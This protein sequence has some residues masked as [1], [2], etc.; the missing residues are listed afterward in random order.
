MIH[1]T[2][3]GTQSTLSARDNRTVQ[4]LFG[5]A[6]GQRQSQTFSQ[7]GRDG[8][9]QGAAGAVGMAGIHPRSA[10][11]FPPRGAPQQDGGVGAPA[12]A[13]LVQ[14]PLGAPGSTT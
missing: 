7:A 4:I 11:G 3:A 9:R 13:P 12:R 10:E 14:T 6:N 8:G 2:G 5:F 1:R